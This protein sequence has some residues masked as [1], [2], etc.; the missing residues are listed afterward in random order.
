MTPGLEGAGPSADNESVI[1]RLLTRARGQAGFGLIELIIALMILNI[2]LLAIVGAFTASAVSLSRAS[3]VSTATALA[4]SHLE[5]FR[6]LDYDEIELNTDDVNTATDATYRTEPGWSTQ[7][8]DAACV[9]A[10]PWW[11]DASRAATGADGREY[12]IDTYVQ[13][14]TATGGRA[15]K[16]VTVVIRDPQA[17]GA[18]PLAR[19]ASTF[20]ASFQ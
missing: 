13:S 7:V 15:V 18:R 5:L 11:C 19:V 4:N 17:L 8:T 2:A 14:Q 10:S 16:W 9:V 3:R 20:D 1:K 12:R 6:S